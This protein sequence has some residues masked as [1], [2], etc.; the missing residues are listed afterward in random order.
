[1]KIEIT[2]KDID[3]G[4]PGNC[5]ECPLALA[6]KRTIAPKYS[7][8]AVHK[9]VR[10]HDYTGPHTVATYAVDAVGVDFIRFFDMGFNVQPCTVELTEVGK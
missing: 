9:S 5:W 2:Q 6:V 3:E 8:V 7:T 1:M 10:I 4:R